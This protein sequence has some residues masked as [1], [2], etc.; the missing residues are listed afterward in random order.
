MVASRTLVARFKAGYQHENQEDLERYLKKHPKADPA[1]HTV[2]NPKGDKKPSGESKGKPEVPKGKAE[3]PQGKNKGKPE[4]KEKPAK[5][6]AP[7]E[8]PGEAPHQEEPKKPLLKRLS[9]GARAFLSTTS[10]ETQRFVSDPKHRKEVL[11]SAGKSILGSP[12]AYAKRILHTVK[13]EVHEFKEAGAAIAHLAK[14]EKL[15][16]HQK[17]ALKT[18]AIHMSVAVA[19]AA[20]TSTGVLAGAAAFGKGMAQKVALKA[21]AQALEK[22]HLLQEFHHI[23]HGLMHLASEKDKPGSPEE[24]F[25]FLVMQSVAKEL[26][27]FSD[28]DLAEVLDAAASKS[29]KQSKTASKPSEFSVLTAKAQKSLESIGATLKGFQRMMLAARSESISLGDTRVWQDRPVAFF[30]ELDDSLETLQ[31]V[32]EGLDDLSLDVAPL[33]NLANEARSILALPRKATVE[34]AI[35]DIDFAANPDTGREGISYSV[36]RL[37]EWAD[38]LGKWASGAI[39]SLKTVDQKAGRILRTKGLV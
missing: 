33:A 16:H 13:E 23:G 25:A 29:Q 36:G 22:V 24:A 18:V 7:E 4:L 30:E 15:N 38:E 27:A 12:K 3:A 31:G 32:G 34:Y 20:L 39:R 11:K 5:P 14:G 28:D 35:S 17:K 19:A 2:K 1:K 9:E 26:E 37:R 10:K 21:A 8:G 6:E